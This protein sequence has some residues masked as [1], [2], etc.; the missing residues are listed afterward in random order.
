[1]CTHKCRLAK[2]YS[3]L[4]VLAISVPAKKKKL[5]IS[6]GSTGKKQNIGK[7]VLLEKLLHRDIG[8]KI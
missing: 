5:T 8:K 2:N 1:M 6:T 4:I 7:K 3:Y